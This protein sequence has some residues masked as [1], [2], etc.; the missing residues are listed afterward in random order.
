MP[1]WPEVIKMTSYAVTMRQI[2]VEVF[3]DQHERAWAPCQ[4]LEADY[5]QV[6]SGWYHTAFFATFSA[7]VMAERE[8]VATSNAERRHIRRALRERRRT[9]RRWAED[10]P[11]N[12]QP[13]ADIV[14]AEIF[15]LRG[16]FPEAMA[17]YERAAAAAEDH[18]IV[19]LVGLASHRLARLARRFGHRIVAKA[20]LDAAHAAYEAWGATGVARRLQRDA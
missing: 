10:C 16:R 4:A 11:E 14:D 8:P 2:M 15:G 5:V 17:A 19:W 20:A 9:I 7:I 3:L 13:M 12:Y 18:R 6:F 1:D